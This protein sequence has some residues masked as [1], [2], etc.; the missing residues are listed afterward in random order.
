MGR[1]KML[2]PPPGLSFALEPLLPK[3]LHTK[4]QDKLDRGEAEWERGSREKKKEKRNSKHQETYDKELKTAEAPPQPTEAVILSETVL[5]PRPAVPPPSPFFS[6]FSFC[7]CVCFSLHFS[8]SSADL[9]RRPVCL[10]VDFQ[11]FPHLPPHEFQCNYPPNKQQNQN[12]MMWTRPKNSQLTISRGQTVLPALAPPGVQWIGV[13]CKLQFPKIDVGW[14]SIFYL[15]CSSF[16]FS[17]DH[18]PSSSALLP[19]CRHLFL[20]L[21][22]HPWNQLTGW[23]G[24]S[25]WWSLR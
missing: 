16:S 7:F 23:A 3:K 12:M 20:K 6:S 15:F 19:L 9:L 11:I 2:S 21:C 13:H 4:S 25:R 10:F 24:R 22:H 17:T 5:R 1:N 14:K 18:L 8:F